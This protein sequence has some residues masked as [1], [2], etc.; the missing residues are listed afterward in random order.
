MTSILS[1]S[2]CLPEISCWIFRFSVCFPGK[3]TIASRRSLFL[4]QVQPIYLRFSVC[5]PGKLTVASRKSL[6]LFQ[7]Q[8]S[9]FILV[10]VIIGKMGFVDL[11]FFPVLVILSFF[12]C[13]WLNLDGSASIL[14]I[15]LL[16]FGFYLLKLKLG[17]F[18]FPGYDYFDL[19]F[20]KKNYKAKNVGGFSSI[21]CLI[22]E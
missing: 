11:N 4:F 12:S 22:Q 9:Y 14:W 3:L 7:V 18:K 13:L 19:F 2:L 8:P 6:F 20:K 17:L 16:P 10:L 15:F 21:L 5:F 1:L